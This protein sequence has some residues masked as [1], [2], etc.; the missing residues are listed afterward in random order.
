M[1]T[2]K[3]SAPEQQKHAYIVASVSN[4]RRHNLSM[5]F[6]TDKEDSPNLKLQWHIGTNTKEMFCLMA[7][8]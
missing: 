3:G 6:G 2:H 5:E 8:D 7:L 4:F 1:K